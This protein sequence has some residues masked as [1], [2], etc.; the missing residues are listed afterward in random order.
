MP[1]VE[2]LNPLERLLVPEIFRFLLEL[3][4][5]SGVIVIVPL[6]WSAAPVRF[7]IALTLLLGVVVH[8]MTTIS[9]EFRGPVDAAAAVV[10]EFTVGLAFGFVVKLALS[11]GEV[12]GDIVTPAMGLGAA[13]IFDPM[14]HVTHAVITTMLRYF[15]TLM[16]L[17]LGL[18]RI[19]LGGLI[20][21]FKILPVAGFWDVSKGWPTIL[22]LSAELLS[23]SVR[24]ALPIL[25]VL[26][27]TN[28]ALAFVARAAPQIQVFS[29]GFAFTLAIGGLILVLVLPDLA[30]QVGADFSHVGR[31][32]ETLLSAIGATT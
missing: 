23:C 14:S 22:Y 3:T 27:I 29:V 12:V 8:G 16:A 21:S 31:R 25:A 9:P 15:T 2:A 10:T 5:I 7:R 1:V 26:F 17:L 13:Q 19:V 32:L 4:R 18:H 20:E 6:A 24:I 30:Y 11:I 28:L